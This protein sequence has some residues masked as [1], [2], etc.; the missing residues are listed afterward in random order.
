M[1]G[2]QTRPKTTHEKRADELQW[3]VDNIYTVARRE[4]R[5]VEDGKPLRPDMW[6]HVLR[7]CEQVGAQSRT[8]GILRT[9]DAVD[10]GVTDTGKPSTRV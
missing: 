7:L 8:V 6:A 10:P 5:R 9:D 3:V 2:I 4:H 1:S